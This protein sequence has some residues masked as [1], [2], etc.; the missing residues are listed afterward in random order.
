[1]ARSRAFG[2]AQ[3]LRDLF[4]ESSARELID[5]KNSVGERDVSVDGTKLDGIETGATADQTASEILTAIKTVDGA[6][7]G[8]DADLLDGVQG[9]SFLRSDTSD[10][11]TANLSFGDNNKVIFG[12]GSDLQIYH[13]GSHSYIQES[14]TGNLYIQGSDLI[15]LGSGDGQE[16]YATFNDDGAVTLYHDNSAKLATTSTGIDVT[17]TAKVT[18]GNSWTTYTSDYGIGTPDSSG[19]QIFAAG[20]DVLRF[21]HS[22]SGTFT[23]RLRIDSSG[24]VGIGTS[25]VDYDLHIEKSNAIGNVDF[26]I[27]NSGTTSSSDT[28]ILSYVSG[29]SGGDPSI[30]VGITGVQDYFWRI[31]NDDSD[32][33]KLDSNGTTRM[34]IDSSGNVGI[35]TAPADKLH[36][37][38]N[39]YLGASSRTIYS[40]GSA[41]LIFQNNTGNMIFSRSNG[42]SESMRIDS[43]GNVGIGTSLPTRPLTVNGNNGTGMII[44]DATNDKALRFRATGDAF[45]IEAT[46]NAESAY[47]NLALEG[48][49]GI[50]TALPSSRLTVSSG[51]SSAA[52]H[53]YT[54][55]EI[56][57]SSH[58]A[59]QFSGSTGAEQWIWFADDASSTPVGGITYYHGGPYMGFRVEG[60]ERM[61]ID[62]SGVVMVSRTSAYNDGT[63][64]TPTFQCGG[65][66]GTRAGIACIQ[67]ST[68]TVTAIGF[69]NPNGT[70]GQISTTGTS[71]TYATSSDYRLKENVVSLAGAADR[72]AQIPVHRFNFIAEPDTTVDGFLAHEVQAFVPEAVTGEKDAVDKDGKPVYQGVDQSKLVPLLTAALQEAIT[73]IED[74]EARVATLEG[75]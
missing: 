38:G 27:R 36:V 15:W 74:L 26:L 53:S 46:N 51:A 17:G 61:R 68:A 49:V 40:G 54:Q 5:A 41:N 29:A 55:L 30:G 31:D 62:S 60:S 39:I 56:E 69:A 67:D 24:R 45:Y 10:T 71:T 33:L 47:A 25:S 65:V 63:I 35:G 52:V 34:T 72:L 11:M 50:G 3:Q 70:V 59:L 57:S 75:N 32:K 22:S 1:M 18:L 42:S 23:E 4:I 12:A 20:G 21:G 64:G 14:G 58:S 16:T 2:F 37:E 6:A 19:L 13:S 7:S 43:S 66:A 44:N 48:N 73:K 9:S 8:L 28:R